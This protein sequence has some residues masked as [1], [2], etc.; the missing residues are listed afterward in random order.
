M[1]RWTL[2]ATLTL[3]AIASLGCATKNYVRNQ[4][5]PVVNKVNEL[6]DLTAKNT[7]DIK[8]V[9]TR[10]QQGIQQVNT[11]SDQADQ[12]AMAAGQRADQ[13]QLTAAQAA[14]GANSLTNTVLNLDKYKPV[15][16]T[17]VHFGFDKSDLA[18]K[19]KKALDQLGAEIATA[20]HYI[21]VVDGNTDGVGAANYNYQL[22]QYRADSVI[23][24]LVTKYNVPAYKIYLIGLGKDKPA[25]TNASSKGRAENRRVDVRLMTNQDDSTSAA[26]QPPSPVQH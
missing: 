14:N 26:M 10:A 1:R 8:D 7:R 21:V 18:P 6:D 4:T 15:V 24:Y 12:K 2:F 11:K 3:F 22:S 20:K 16:E 17:T 9:D 5:A 13:A 19:A 25:A 23:K